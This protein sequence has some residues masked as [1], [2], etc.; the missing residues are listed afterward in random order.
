MSR[1]GASLSFEAV[2]AGKKSGSV[3]MGTAAVAVS[4]GLS[5]G[6]EGGGGDPTTSSSSRVE[7]LS[8]PSEPLAIDFDHG[9]IELLLQHKSMGSNWIPVCG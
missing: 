9:R 5:S 6:S 2:T 1:A 3:L 4:G 7:H 8:F